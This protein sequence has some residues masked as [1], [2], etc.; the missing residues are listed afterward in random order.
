MKAVAG[1]E[2]CAVSLLTNSMAVEGDAPAEAIVEAVTAA[3]YG[4]SP[5]GAEKKPVS[6]KKTGKIRGQDPAD[7]A[8]LLVGAAAAV[9]V[10]HHGARH[11]GLAVPKELA[12]NAMAQGLTQLLL[13]TAVLVI[14]QKFFKSGVRGLLH[15]APNMDTLVSLGA[16]AAY[17]YSLAVLYRL[18]AMPGAYAYAARAVF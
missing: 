16:A 1:V 4:A 8:D 6:P 2:R 15:R 9:D 14:N 7:T 3:G 11:V 5:K 10:S 18:T 12:E 13:T 17:G